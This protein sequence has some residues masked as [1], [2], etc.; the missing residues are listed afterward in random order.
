MAQGECELVVHDDRALLALQG[1][2]AVKVPIP[3]YSQQLAYRIYR[4]C[5]HASAG[6]DFQPCNEPPHPARISAS[7]QVLQPLIDLDLTNVYFSDFHKL[8]IKG[9]PSYLTRTGYMIFMQNTSQYQTCGKIN[10]H[11]VHAILAHWVVPR[12]DM[13][14]REPRQR[15]C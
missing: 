2:S 1:P 11:H 12:V 10:T 7:K 4:S 14:R 3:A 8:D 13:A 6:A 15:S 5:R 9:L